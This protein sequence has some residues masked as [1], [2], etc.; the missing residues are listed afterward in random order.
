VKK[1]TFLFC[2]YGFV[3]FAMDKESGPCIKLNQNPQLPKATR[4]IFKS[5]NYTHVPWGNV[6]PTDIIITPNQAGLVMSRNGEVLLLNFL[7]PKTHLQITSYESIITHSHSQHSPMIGVAKAKDESLVVASAINYEN[8]DVENY[9]S[10]Y[11]RYHSRSYKIEK[12]KWLIQAIAL[13]PSGEILAIAGQN[14]VKIIDFVMNRQHDI[15]IPDLSKEDFFVD[16]ALNFSDD[17]PI[18]VVVVDNRGKIV[19]LAWGPE[20]DD[21]RLSRL[22]WKETKDGIKKLS[23]AKE[24][25]YLTQNNQIKEVDAYALLGSDLGQVTPVFSCLPLCNVAIF[26]T[27]EYRT[28]ACWHRDKNQDLCVRDK[29]LIYKQ[30]GQS[31]EEVVL[32]APLKETYIYRT[33]GGVLKTAKNCIKSVALRDK[34]VVALAKDGILHRWELQ[35]Q[36]K[37]AETI[38]ET[39][40]TVA[41][42]SNIAPEPIK[43]S[44]SSKL[45][46]SLFQITAS[47]SG[48]RESVRP[49]KQ[50]DQKKRNRRSKSYSGEYSESLQKTFESLARVAEQE[51]ESRA[52]SISPE[53]SVSK[54]N[55]VVSPRREQQS[56]SLPEQGSKMQRERAR[57]VSTAPTSNRSVPDSALLSP[58]TKD[59]KN[60]TGNPDQKTQKTSPRVDALKKELS[61]RPSRESSPGSSPK[62]KSRRNSTSPR[63]RSNSIDIKKNEDQAS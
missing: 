28:I 1:C 24:L 13:D 51:S 30:K 12:L 11:T 31:Q 59:Q 52:E 20:D 55:S 32:E 48:S 18:R 38:N 10:E 5:A 41:E 4:S 21:C 33:K 61:P 40:V 9:S 19:S 39:M 36:P 60:I 22:S 14:K 23:Y 25:L 6:R 53:D 15:L 26:N 57:S 35:Q 58:R 43:S 47:S 7:D 63:S 45:R 54:S 3:L 42:L 49:T 62:S 17:T 50:A 16:I 34:C 29:I 2:L 56:K 37:L 46:R 8:K 27:S 44:N